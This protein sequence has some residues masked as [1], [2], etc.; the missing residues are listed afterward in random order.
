MTSHP[1][2]A[3]AL[4]VLE[5]VPLSADV[6]SGLADADLL[7]ASEEAARVRQAVEAHLAVIA[8]EIGRRSARELGS[9]GLAQRLG[10][11]TP[12]E[13]VRVTIRSSAREAATAVRVGR[14][15]VTAEEP[16]LGGVSEGVLSGVLS[17]ASAD[18]IRTG[19]GSPSEGVSEAVLCEAAALL[20][21]EG[22]VL[23]PDRLLRR[24]RQV[25]D[26]LDEA[27][28]A[29]REAARR[30]RR[31]LRFTRLPD[32][33]S[34]AVW[35][36]DP[37]TSA[38]FGSLFDRATSPRRGGPRFVGEE[39][40][41]VT[42]ALLADD[43]TTEQ[44]ASDVFLEL[45]RHGAAAD[46]SQLLGS[47]GA[48]ITVHVGT[49]AGHGFLEGQA[50]AVSIQTVQRLACS[51]GVTE[52]AFDEHGQAL[53]VGREQRLFT[54]RQRRALAARD[55]GCRAPGCD[56]P[57]SWTEAHHITPWAIGGRTDIADGILL[58]R[59]HH[60]LFHNNGW[61]IERDGARYWLIPPPDIGPRMLLE[62]K[63]PVR[64][65]ERAA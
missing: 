32:G 31:S 14:L 63:N 42:E 7:A 28:I 37:E 61:Q 16:W 65:Q 33:M 3:A 38:V 40:R 41:A 56:R 49:G 12:E 23:D 20:C 51:G 11:R 39:D 24:A 46:S 30:G 60:L 9:A 45:L 6:Y 17:V 53:D 55:G 4:A 1:G 21:G 22:A 52:V 13:L 34:R 36:M 8:G 43:R 18:A 29:D 25:R 57:P 54:R 27:G 2:F 35:V 15:V 64:R 62:S 50:D 47:G 19:L 26:E 44:L 58:C 10:A 59:H 5:G 48:T